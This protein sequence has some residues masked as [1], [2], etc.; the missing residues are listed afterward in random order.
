MN[1][2]PMLFLHETS[3]GRNASIRGAL[4]FAF[5]GARPPTLSPCAAAG[6]TLGTAVHPPRP[7][8]S[9]GLSFSRAEG[10]GKGT[11]AESI[12]PTLSRGWRGRGSPPAGC[13]LRDDRLSRAQPG[14]V[15]SWCPHC[16]P[17][18]VGPLRGLP[19]LHVLG[20]AWILIP[21]GLECFCPPWI[22]VRKKTLTGFSAGFMGI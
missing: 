7:V 19:C 10:G 15:R 4:R 9:G 20:A 2:N 17:W 1:V 21:H 6:G 3:S 14:V 5:P 13:V 11:R 16:L 12:A 18:P 22:L 8:P